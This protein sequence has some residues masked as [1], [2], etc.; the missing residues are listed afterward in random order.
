MKGPIFMQIP[1]K[2]FFS[3]EPMLGPIKSAYIDGVGYDEEGNEICVPTVDAV[4]LGG[5][6]GSGARPLHPDWVRSV[7]DQCSDANV[8]FFFKQWGQWAA[9]EGGSYSPQDVYLP[10]D[11]SLLVDDPRLNVCP[12]ER[13]GRKAAGRLMDGRTHDDLPWV[14]K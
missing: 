11:G 14:T 7:R 5:E 13:V 2:K 9:H 3:F 8:P 10:N 6:T 4:I 1:G 12:M